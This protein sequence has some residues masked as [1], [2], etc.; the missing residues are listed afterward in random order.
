MIYR[1]TGTLYNNSACDWIIIHDP[2]DE[3]T[4]PVHQVTC[5]TYADGTVY[6][7]LIDTDHIQLQLGDDIV[8]N[9][10][11]SGKALIARYMLE[12][13]TNADSINQER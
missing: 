8:V 10:L 11:I 5:S 7:V 3:Y 9:V 13:Q 6:Q 2:D 12:H 4:I 1:V